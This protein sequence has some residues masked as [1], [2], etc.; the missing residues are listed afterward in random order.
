ML[1]QCHCAELETKRCFHKICDAVLRVKSLSS[2]ASQLVNHCAHLGVN[3][4]C[5]TWVTVDKRNFTEDHQATEISDS[6]YQHGVLF[7]AAPSTQLY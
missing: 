3:M 1:V 6:H 4:M 5:V 7:A 2:L